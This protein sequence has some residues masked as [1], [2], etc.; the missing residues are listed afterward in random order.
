MNISQDETSPNSEMTSKSYK[1]LLLG[2]SYVGK[3][4]ILLRYL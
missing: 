4:C 1:V 2:N 3:T